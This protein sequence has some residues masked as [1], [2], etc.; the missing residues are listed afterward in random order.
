MDQEGNEKE[1][2]LVF[3]PMI[4]SFIMEIIKADKSHKDHVLRLLDNF[5]TFYN[6]TTNPERAL[7][8]TI[9][10]ESGGPMFDTI[11]DSSKSAIFLVKDEGD[12]IGIA[13]VYKIPQIRHGKYCAEIEEMYIE[14]KFHGKGVAKIL[15]NAIIEWAKENGLR[16]VRLESSN[17][18]K[19]AHSFYEKTGFKFYGR[20]YQKTIK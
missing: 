3:I 16:S 20:A 8:S 17:E 10:K 6:E 15:I 19:R 4:Q 13:T 5:I 7:I 18:L 9:A 2:D 11:V 14:P 12:Y 1:R